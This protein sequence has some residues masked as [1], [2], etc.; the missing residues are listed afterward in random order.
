MAS[1]SMANASSCFP[2]SPSSNPRDVSKKK[3]ANRSAKLKQCKLDARREQFLSQVK[4][5]ECKGEANGHGGTVDVGKERGK[6]IV[7]LEIKPRVEAENELFINNYN[8]DTESAANSTTSNA[9]SFLGSNDFRTNY[10]GS[11]S[12]S[13]SS[14]GRC[15]LGSMSGDDE[16]L[17]DWEAFA[18]ALAATDK[19][20]ERENDMDSLHE[21]EGNKQSY[22]GS[23]RCFTAETRTSTCLEIN[24][25]TL[26]AVDVSQQKQESGVNVQRAS[27]SNCSAWRPDDAFRPQSLPNLSKQ[28]SFPM[29]TD[30]NFGLGEKTWNYDNTISELTSCPICTEDF[31]VTDTN[32]LPCLCGYRLCLFCYKRILEYNDARCPGCRRQYDSVRINADSTSDG[33][34]LTIRLARSCSMVTRS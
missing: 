21:S 11:S 32:F 20:Q 3:R 1:D 16:C 13:S 19:K 5:K 7:K 34:S 17:E 27:V 8:S 14:S 25:H 6:T 30:R 22:V 31:D 26:V 2:I 28:F 10:T 15:G 23:S 9:S 29:D 12:R 18:D 33:C 24:N 4:N